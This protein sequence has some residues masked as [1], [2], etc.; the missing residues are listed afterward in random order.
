MNPVR[1]RTVAIKGVARYWTNEEYVQR[2]HKMLIK[3][4][5]DIEGCQDMQSRRAS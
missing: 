2:A 1:L 5:L 3:S 4:L